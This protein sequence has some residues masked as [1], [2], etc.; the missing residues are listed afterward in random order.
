MYVFLNGKK[1]MPIKNGD[2]EKNNTQYLGIPDFLRIN[3]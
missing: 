2:F 1:L 3:C